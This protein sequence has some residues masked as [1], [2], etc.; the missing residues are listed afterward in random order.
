ML[1]LLAAA[2]NAADSGDA[3]PRTALEAKEAGHYLAK[4][5]G[6]KGD[7]SPF[8]MWKYARLG[9]IPHRRLGRHVWFLSDELDAFAS[10]TGDEVLSK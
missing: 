10:G 3:P 2:L 5:L 8:A 4:R 6:L 1:T 9:Q 7:I